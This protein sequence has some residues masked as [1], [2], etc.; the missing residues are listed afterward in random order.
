MTETDPFDALLDYVE[1][2][3]DDAATLA[4]IGPLLEPAFAGII[5]DF[6]DAIAK[7]P[8]AARVFTGGQTQI[9]R[10]KRKLER[11]LGEL[12]EGTY[13]HEYFHRR[14]VIG[15]RHV[16]ISL[17][18]H[19]M[20]GAMNRI[21][22]GLHDALDSVE[23][24]PRHDGHR[25]IDK[26][27]DIE[28]GIMLETYR[29]RFV[30]RQRARER[31][32]TMGQLAASIGHELRNPLAVI[33]TSVHLLKK[34]VSE[35]DKALRHVSKVER[36]VGVANK[37]VTDLLSMVRDRPPQREPVELRAL[38]DEVLE[39]LPHQ[40]DIALHIAIDPDLGPVTV[41][42]LQCRQCISN[43]L[44]N[45]FDALEGRAD[46]VVE[47]RAQAEGDALVIEVLDNGPGF[48]PGILGDVFEP[49]TTTRDTGVGLGLALCRRVAEG[50][51][52]EI[53]ARDREEGGAIV[54]LVI[55]GA[56][57]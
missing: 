33:S 13:D 18:Q 23:G 44:A 41:D 42:R 50:H 36:Q 12:F 4:E 55:P 25:A 24:A 51:G 16:Q 29:E 43:L 38:V 27:C 39:G 49:L 7:R 34:R 47:L 45:A 56:Q 5:D 35:D 48:D 21:R 15:R 57:P 54:T 52:G 53:R 40:G 46:G 6:Y 26:I 9:D 11:W 8:R 30:E 14:C 28:L 19:Y 22:R 1:F 20:F 10:Q 37:I 2:A 31:L 17:P 32:A 3:A